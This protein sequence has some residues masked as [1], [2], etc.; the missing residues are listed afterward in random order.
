MRL[1]KKNGVMLFW[2]LLFLDCYF[3]FN[4]QE[5]YHAYI[6]VLL[7]PV[8][9]LFVFLN[10]RKKHFTRSKTLIYLG[11]IFSWIGDILLLQND[12]SFFVAGT[13]AFLATHIFYSIFFYRVHSIGGSTSSYEVVIIAT[14]IIAAF[15]IFAINF[16]NEDLPSY[17]KL[18]FYIYLAA[19]GIMAILATNI[20]SNR[21]KQRLAIQYF[22]PGAALFIISDFVLATHRF[23]YLDENF[24]AVIVMLTYGYAQCFLAQG[25]AKYLKG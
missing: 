5:Q 20:Y 9:F 12:E 25:F 17:F 14:I 3:V 19:I 2:A 6:K 10:A 15:A 11:L 13:I 8:L 1:L 7:I 23:V 4:Q 24:L 21:G 16:F 18:P 22:I